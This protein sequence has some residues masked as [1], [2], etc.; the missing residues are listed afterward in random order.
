MKAAL[1]SALKEDLSG[2]DALIMTA[3]VA[4]FRP[5]SAGDKKLKRAEMGPNPTIALTAN[6]DLIAEIGAARSGPNPYLVAFALETV[7]G[8]AL[9]DAARGKLESKSVD[10]VVANRASDAFD[11]DDNL[12]T[13]V[14]SDEADALPLLSKRELADRILDRVALAISEAT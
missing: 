9:V 3:A 1:W 7:E 13:L 5:Q 11:K 10:L 8:Q 4:D 6:P 14:N 12:A 2:A